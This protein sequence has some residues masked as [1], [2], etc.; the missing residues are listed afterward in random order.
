[1][2]LA[3]SLSSR[4]EVPIDQIRSAN[5]ASRVAVITLQAHVEVTIEFNAAV[6][7]PT[8][9]DRPLKDNYVIEYFR[10]GNK[11]RFKE[12]R[13]P[14][15]PRDII[16][17]FDTQKSSLFLPKQD[18]KSIDLG[19]IDE[20]WKVFPL[21]LWQ[22]ALFEM[23]DSRQ[24][25]SQLLAD[26][27]V[28]VQKT[29]T[30][31]GR[32]LVYLE[33]RDSKDQKYEVWVDPAANYLVRKLILHSSKGQGTI[34]IEG[35]VHSFREVKPGVYF[36]DRM[37]H[38]L[39]IKGNWFEKAEA[40][41]TNLNVRGS[42]PEGTFK[43]VF[44]TGTRVAD[45]EKGTLYTVGSQGQPTKVGNLAAPSQQA[46]TATATP[47][48]ADDERWAWHHFLLIGSGIAVGAGVL[49]LIWKRWRRGA[50]T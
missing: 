2:L 16:R 30:S 36:P 12:T 4:S 3:F 6:V 50:T 45:W 43:H 42:L 32:E 49:A 40:K 25:F 11:E 38:S 29:T 15:A 14:L 17:D 5:E 22:W 7:P 1:M 37:G 28:K 19:A 20:D 21:E 39:F 33:V 48:E 31:G 34:R 41:L 35:E 18:R 24:S 46:P 26:G 8:H 47:L 23:P 44:P 27:Q 9:P 13:G 10:S